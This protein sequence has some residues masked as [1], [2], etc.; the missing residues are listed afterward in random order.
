MN[1][2]LYLPTKD[3]L[4]GPKVG[5]YRDDLLRILLNVIL[6]NSTICFWLSLVL[7]AYN[8]NSLFLLLL[9]QEFE[10]DHMMNNT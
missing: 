3:N 1:N 10:L 9:R 5:L 6:K 2:Q 4:N 8:R 7:F